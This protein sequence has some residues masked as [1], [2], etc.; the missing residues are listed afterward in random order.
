MRHWCQSMSDHL[1]A[2]DMGTPRP[3]LLKSLAEGL[4]WL[5]STSLSVLTQAKGMGKRCSELR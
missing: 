1:G 2:G 4:G 5:V 3:V